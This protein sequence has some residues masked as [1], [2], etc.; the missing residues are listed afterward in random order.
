MDDEYTD[1]MFGNN[2]QDTAINYSSPSL[3]YTLPETASS[4][5]NSPIYNCF[6]F[7]SLTPTE[8][9]PTKLG[10]KKMDRKDLMIDPVHKSISAIVVLDDHA[11]RPTLSTDSFE[12][13]NE[14]QKET[15]KQV[16]CQLYSDTTNNI[17]RM[18][19]E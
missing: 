12:V 3:Q 17:L 11:Y 5:N 8:Y 10:T 7:D 2:V 16:T 18:Q 9:L 14:N 4:L 13:L 15:R 1:S 19:K 6:I